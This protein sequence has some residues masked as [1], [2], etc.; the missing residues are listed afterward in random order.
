MATNKK[1]G[2]ICAVFA[3]VTYGMNP[4]FG[5]PLYAEGLTPLSVLFYRFSLASLLMAGVL[6]FSKESFRLPKRYWLHTFCGGILVGLTCLF[7]FLSFRIMD[8][9]IAATILF[10]YPVMVAMIMFLF[11]REKLSVTTITGTAI[12]IAGVVLL[13]QPGSG[14]RFSMAGL[15]YVI[16]SALAYSIYI[17][18]VKE[19]R[20]RELS[21]ATLTFYTLLFAI[22]VFLIPLRMGA[23]LQAIPSIKALCNAIGLGLFPSLLSFLLTAVAVKHIGPTQTSVMGGL[24]PVTAVLIGIFFFREHASFQT[25]IGIIM[26]L[27][28]VTVIICNKTPAEKSTPVETAAD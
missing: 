3:A 9:G 24:E 11:F 16:L 12:A 22:P 1:I 23:D 18:G 19:S 25:V 2:Y 7:W 26:I 5:L 15:I 17:V 28:A 4:F 21:S 27:A 14:A 20:L 10:V 6:F 8:S 13:C